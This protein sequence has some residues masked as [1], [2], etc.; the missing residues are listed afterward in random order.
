MPD[1]VADGG[2][3]RPI[4]TLSRQEQRTG[5]EKTLSGTPSESP[6]A[7]GL[8]GLSGPA[9]TTL[10]DV[11]AAAATRSGTNVFDV[12]AQHQSTRPV[13]RPQPAAQNPPTI[14]NTVT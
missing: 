10:P 8:A 7:S 3:G 13:N 1:P 9:V 11:R 6:P 4:E 14:R 5:D 12:S 2:G